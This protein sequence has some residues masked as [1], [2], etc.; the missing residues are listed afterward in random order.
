MHEKEKHLL[1]D[2]ILLNLYFCAGE[3]GYKDERDWG[4]VNLD[5]IANSVLFKKHMVDASP[6][7]M[8]KADFQLVKLSN[9]VATDT[10][11]L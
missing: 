7:E 4:W 10:K 11:Y 8:Y 5:I 3:E 1:P 9:T 2:K 6:Q